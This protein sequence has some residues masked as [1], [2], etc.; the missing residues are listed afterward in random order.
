MFLT[1]ACMPVAGAAL[2]QTATGDL[3]VQITITGGC[4]L[5]TVTNINFGT[6]SILNDKIE[7]SGSI[8]VL[9]T[10]GEPYFITL[11]AGIAPGA[12]VNDRR[13]TSQSGDTIQYQLYQDAP[14][15]KIWG[16]TQNVNAVAGTGTGSAETIPI[17]GLVPSQT[18]PRAGV[19][20]DTVTVTLNY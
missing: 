8:S 1:L 18:T 14:R 7:G 4:V 10:T 12:T 11:G 19:Y 16:V 6:H 9:C 13:M 2:A 17:Y 15:T 5:D 20:T 3:S